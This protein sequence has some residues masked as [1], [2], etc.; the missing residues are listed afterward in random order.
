MLDTSPFEPQSAAKGSKPYK[1][2]V[3]GNPEPVYIEERFLKKAK[4]VKV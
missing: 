1:V 3:V 4:K 2:L